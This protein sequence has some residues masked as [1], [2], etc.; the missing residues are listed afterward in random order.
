[1]E[2]VFLLILGGDEAE[3]AIGNDLLDGTGGHG[4]LQHF[5]NRGSRG[6][7]SVREGSDH[8]EHATH[9]GETPP[10]HTDPGSLCAVGGPATSLDARVA[11]ESDGFGEHILV[12]QGAR[13]TLAVATRAHVARLAQLVWLPELGRRVRDDREG[14]VG[15]QERRDRSAVVLAPVGVGEERL[16]P[17][18]IAKI[19]EG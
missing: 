11:Q 19:V 15:A 6:E 17:D 1:M 7:R 16:A 9:R 2:E 10:Y 13:N 12:R 4:D 14:E 18:A 8:A 5:P 3:A